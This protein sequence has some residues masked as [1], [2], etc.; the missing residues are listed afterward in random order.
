MDPGETF[1]PRSGTSPRPRK[2][3]PNRYLFSLASLT[4]GPQQSDRVSF[5][6]LALISPATVSP[7]SNPPP[8]L[9]PHL[10]LPF[11]D[12]AEPIKSPHSSLS[13]PFGP[14]R[15]PSPNRQRF[16]AGAT[17][18]RHGNPSNPTNRRYPSS[19]LRSYSRSYNL[20]HPLM[21]SICSN[22]Q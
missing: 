10:S 16:L 5:F 17:N 13:S 14:S 4:C 11:Q 15:N 1:R 21:S 8:L 7:R 6:F 19:S 18:L 9:I 22:S 12:L 2:N 3:N 20:V